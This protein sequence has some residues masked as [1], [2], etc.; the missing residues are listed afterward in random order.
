MDFMRYCEDILEPTL[1]MV[2]EMCLKGYMKKEHAMALMHQMTNVN[3][4]LVNEDS[5]SF[6]DIINS[7][8]NDFTK[9][10]GGI[11]V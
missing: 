7:V 3:D 5:S 9:E 1:D 2:V 4:C 6:H 10:L 11:R 8:I